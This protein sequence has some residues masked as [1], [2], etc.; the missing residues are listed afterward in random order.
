MSEASYR[1]IE[2]HE[3]ISS[4]Y[5]Y[6]APVRLWHWLNAAAVLVLGVT[7]YLIG[8]PLPSYTGD[9]SSVYVMGLIRFA[10]LT[11]GHIFAVLW[12]GRI[13]WAVIGN[14]FAR[15]LF[16][17][18]VWSARWVEGMR[19]QLAW[20]LFMVKTARRYSGLNPLAHVVMLVAFVLPSLVVLLTGYA[21]YAEVAGHESWLYHTF[22]WM[23]RITP[24]TID[25]HTVHRLCMWVMASF[26]LIHVYTAVREDIVSRQSMVSTMLSGYRLF[27]K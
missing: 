10:H 27:K 4:L 22:G 12:V 3:D 19:Y 6:E 18:P 2:D 8:T 24:N 7:G 20:N 25:F 15:Q 23:T 11:A 17:P 14:A 26:V 16:I 5:I 9:P 13:W 1:E 21:M